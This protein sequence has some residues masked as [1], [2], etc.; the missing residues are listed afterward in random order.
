M[1]KV[2]L[3]FNHL[4]I[5]HVKPFW[6]LRAAEKFMEKNDY[7]YCREVEYLVEDFYK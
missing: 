2:W 5:F 7:C 1:K 4:N 3:V 6:T